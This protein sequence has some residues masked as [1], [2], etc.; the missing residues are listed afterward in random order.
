MENGA[1][2]GEAVVFPG[3][4]PTRFADVG[5]FMVINPIARELVAV[6]NDTLGYSLVERFKQ[7]PGDYSEYA[8]AAFLIN[9]LAMARWAEQEHGARPE[10][11]VGPSFGGKAA[12]IYSG[13][14]DPA[15]GI[16]M[17]VRLARLQ[18]EFFAEEHTDVVTSSFARVPDEALREVLDGM[19]A[20]G[21][22]YDIACRVDRDFHMVSLRR[23]HLDAFKKELRG[24]GGLPLYEMHPPMHSSA[25]GN[26]RK[27]A[28]AEIFA[29]L[30]FRDPKLPVIA[31]Q[32]GTVITT[33]DGVRTLLLDGFVRA[34]QW[35]EAVA[36][37]QQRGIS[38]VYVCGQD[39]LFG[40]VGVTTRTFDVVPVNP[41]MVMRPK[42]R[43]KAR[44][45]A[46]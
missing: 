15:Q 30:E 43:P 28:D 25:F 36:A 31:D 29:D 3:M 44:R 37:L 45:Q 4:G 17:A 12:A 6:S 23:E 32:D 10:A 39:S 26:L 34:V 5:K 33:A 35:P 13:A 42:R 20:R 41:Q 11:C 7:T 16:S 14:L 8:Q 9:C 19:D 24:H 2:T 38:K 40:R 1:R 27:R 21:E 46:G 22:W 18:D